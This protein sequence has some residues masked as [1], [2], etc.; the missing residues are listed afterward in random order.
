MRV[1]ALGTDYTA[2]DLIQAGRDYLDSGDRLVQQDSETLRDDTNAKE[3]WKHFQVITGIVV[4]E[5]ELDSVPFCC[6]C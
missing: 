5:S 6:T 1:L 2:E 3:F 4:P